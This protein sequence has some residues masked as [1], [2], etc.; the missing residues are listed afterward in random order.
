MNNFLKGSLIYASGV[1]GGFMIGS[2]VTLTIITKSNIFQTVIKDTISKA[3]SDYIFEENN[4]C[5]PRSKSGY[6]SYRKFYN[7]ERN[8]NQYKDILV[9]TKKDAEDIISNIKDCFETYGAVSIADVYDLCTISSSYKDNAIGW[10]TQDDISKINFVET[11]L[12]YNLIFPE[13]V[14]L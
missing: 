5:K 1:T 6:V 7:K 10:N 14:V 3:A 12:G 8:E 11:N 9:E 4:R 2:V 13:P